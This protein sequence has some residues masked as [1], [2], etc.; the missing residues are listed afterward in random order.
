VPRYSRL[1]PS[2]AAANSTFSAQRRPSPLVGLVESSGTLIFPSR[3][4]CRPTR[5]LAVALIEP[6]AL[7]A[8]KPVF[9]PTHGIECERIGSAPLAW[10]IIAMNSFDTLIQDLVIANRI[11][12]KE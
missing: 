5:S 8:T 6:L 12:V 10:M 11:L 4:H 1:G 3:V 2:G 9:A 7:I